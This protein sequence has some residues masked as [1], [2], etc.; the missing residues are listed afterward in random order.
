MAD[1]APMLPT[2]RAQPIKNFPTPIAAQPL[3]PQS[4]CRMLAEMGT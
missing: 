1:A 2:H 3:D 4:K